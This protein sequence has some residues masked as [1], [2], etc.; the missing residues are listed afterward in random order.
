MSYTFVQRF[1][2]VCIYK[3]AASGLDTGLDYISCKNAHKVTFL[4]SHFGVNDTDLA[5]IGLIE[6]TDVAAG[7]SAAVTAT[8]PMWY[9]ATA[10]FS[11]SDLWTR[12]ATEAATYTGPSAVDGIDPAAYGSTSILIEWDPAKH[13]AG[14]DCISVRATNG[15]G[16][17]NN[18]VE[19]WAFIE[20]RYPQAIPGTQITD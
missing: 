17:A 7:T 10:T 5:G 9:I 6:A 3:G 18:F 13:T 15:T 11:T 1:S 14:Y 4:V 16:H 8:V 19:V 2:P 20:Q 12:Q